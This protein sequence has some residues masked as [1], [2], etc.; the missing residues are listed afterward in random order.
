MWRQAAATRLPVA[1]L[2]VENYFIDAGI[3]EGGGRLSRNR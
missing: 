3:D 1:K 2:P